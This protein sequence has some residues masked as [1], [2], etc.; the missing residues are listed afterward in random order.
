MSTLT[1]RLDP[2][3]DKIIEQLK[4]YTGQN[5]ASKALICAAAQVLTRMRPLEKEN[6]RLERNLSEVRATISAIQSHYR[7]IDSSEKQIRQLIHLDSK[8][9]AQDPSGSADPKEF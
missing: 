6:A 5:S 1:L 3:E 8:K 2:E 4:D 9:S 7:A